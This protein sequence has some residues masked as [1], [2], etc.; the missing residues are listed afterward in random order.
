VFAGLLQLAHLVL[1]LLLL[2]L[3]LGPGR[4]RGVGRLLGESVRELIAGFRE[5]SRGQV[6]PPASPAE[7]PAAA[8]PARPCP[9]C[10]AWSVELANYCTRCGTRLDP[11]SKE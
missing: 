2:V 1:V 4:L 6:E 5:G 11:S 9:R 10:A 8:L 3:V 7:P